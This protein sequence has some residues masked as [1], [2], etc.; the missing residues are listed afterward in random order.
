MHPGAGTCMVVFVKKSPLQPAATS[1]DQP[2]WKV[3]QGRM[4]L[5]CVGAGSIRNDQVSSDQ[6]RGLLFGAADA[7]VRAS[8]LAWNVSAMMLGHAAR[9]RSM[10]T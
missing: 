1:K 8:D 10:Q 9:P 4:F 6:R 7:S 5:A 3:M 2:P